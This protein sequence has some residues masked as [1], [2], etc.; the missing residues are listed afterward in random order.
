MPLARIPELAMVRAYLDAEEDT[1]RDFTQFKRNY[2]KLSMELAEAS[3]APAPAQAQSLLSLLATHPAV[4]PTSA[5][6]RQLVHDFARYPIFTLAS[7]SI[8][9]TWLSWRMLAGRV[10]SGSNASTSRSVFG[11]SNP[12]PR[13]KI[14]G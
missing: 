14:I 1:R 9:A 13:P 7:I 3:T 12:Q 10:H 8:L 11:I 6:A 4:S 5:T 2:R